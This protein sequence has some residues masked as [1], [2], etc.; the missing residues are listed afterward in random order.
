MARPTVYVIQEPVKRDEVTG[1][2]VSMMDF[3]KVVEYGDPEVLLPSGR[4][5]LAPGPTIDILKDKLRNFSDNDYIVSVGDPSAIFITAMIAGE[6][7]RGRVK[8]LKWDKPARNYI[9]VNIDLNYRKRG[10][11]NV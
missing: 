8:L 11:E 5:S 10:L 6:N 7:N 4:V 2:M 3:R 9:S 1:E